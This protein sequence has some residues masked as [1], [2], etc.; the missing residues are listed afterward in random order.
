[1][2]KRIQLE[3]R[4][5]SP[6]KIKELILDNCKATTIEGLNDEFINLE[7]LT[8]INVGLTSLKNFPTLPNLKKLDISDNRISD[9]LKILCDKAPRLVRLNLAGNN[10]SDFSAI[11]PLKNLKDLISLDLFNCGI[12]HKDGFRDKIFELI[13][14]LQYLDGYDRD[15]KDESESDL[16]PLND[17]DEDDD[18]DEEEEDPDFDDD[19]DDDEDHPLHDEDDDDEDEEEGAG[20][21]SING[22]G[23]KK[24]AAPKGRQP[25]KAPTAEQEDEDDEEDDDDEGEDGNES[26]DEEAD[27]AGDKVHV[28][29][30]VK[31]KNKKGTKR[32]LQGAPGED[33]EDEEEEYDD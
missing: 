21:V 33:D 2:E 30:G 3:T 23:V 11:Q 32:K 1:M 4:G 13:P 14:G 19:E 28:K 12:Q 15:N 7:N 25:R 27:E 17:D 5:R 9:G 24:V 22:G 10:I 6:S 16:D 20:D 18:D 29:G 8:F 31:N 26:D